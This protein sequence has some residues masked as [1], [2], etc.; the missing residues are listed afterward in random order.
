MTLISDFLDVDSFLQ[1]NPEYRAINRTE[2]DKLEVGMEVRVQ[3][4]GEYLRIRVDEID[5]NIIKGTVVTK[6]FYQQHSFVY[7]DQIQFYK[8]NVIDIYDINRWGV[9]L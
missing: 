7:L 9:K 1:V 4:N 2:L 3:H 5:D 6:L 8:K